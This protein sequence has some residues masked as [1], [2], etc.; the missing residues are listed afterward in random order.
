MQQQEPAQRVGG[1]ANLGAKRI[2]INWGDSVAAPNAATQ[3][4]TR[5]HIVNVAAGPTPGGSV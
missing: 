4:V 2:Y 1:S 5:L 3:D